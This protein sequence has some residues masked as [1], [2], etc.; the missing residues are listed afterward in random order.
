MANRWWFGASFG[1]FATLATLAT[2]AACGGS[3]DDDGGAGGSITIDDLP[4]AVAE[5]QCGL[6]E[7]CLGDLYKV[8]L[9]A[10]DCVTITQRRV[11]NGE[12][13]QL[14]AAVASG[15][16]KYDG[17]AA[18]KCLSEIANRS[19]DDLLQR[20]SA[21]C[22]AA[23]E[24]N[25][26]T[27]GECDFDF[28]CQ[29]QAFC[30]VTAGACPGACTDRQPAGS[31]CNDD[32]Q[33]ADGLV[34]YETTQACIAPVGDAQSCE[35]ASAPPCEP[36][37]LCIGGDEAAGTPGTCK[38]SDDAFNGA[39]GEACSFQTGTLCSVNLACVIDDFA[40]LSGTCTAKA[41]AGGTCTP[42]SIP[43]QCP[44]DQY[45]A[46]A[47]TDPSGT[48]TALP[49][50]GQPCVDVLGDPACAPYARCENGTCRDLQANGGAC[51]TPAVC[52][53]NVCIG[54][55]CRASECAQ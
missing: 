14:E 1:T 50:D 38:P 20:T 30:K 34:C 32:D 4:K 45:C 42:A 26:A 25:V 27:G 36:G 39:V 55:A 9:G 44:F 11:E 6:Y 46:G 22:D 7:K 49:T 35:G 41:A 31:S 54:G 23:V 53:S 24:G 10:E 52:Y 18:S 29:G 2:V 8:F 47:P 13:A 37:Y 40:T 51:A 33:C 5:A 3:S 17:A 43:P 12:L 48:C 19:C 15:D 16:V 28:Q 21:T